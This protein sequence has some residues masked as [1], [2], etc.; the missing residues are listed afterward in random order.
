MREARQQR[1][2]DIARCA[3]R[4]EKSEAGIAGAGAGAL[5]HSCHEADVDGGG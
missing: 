4:M 1:L 3:G 2:P 5:A